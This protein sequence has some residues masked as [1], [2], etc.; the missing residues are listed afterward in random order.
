MSDASPENMALEPS[1]V[2]VPAEMPDKASQELAMLGLS[3]EFPEK[4]Q[5]LNQSLADSIGNSHS[6]FAGYKFTLSPDAVR[7][8]IETQQLY[9]YPFSVEL[10]VS[11]NMRAVLN[12][13]P[14]TEASVL[15]AVRLDQLQALLGTANVGFTATVYEPLS[16]NVSFTKPLEELTEGELTKVSP[17]SDIVIGA[18]STPVGEWPMKFVMRASKMNERGREGII[19]TIRIKDLTV[20][21]SSQVVEASLSTVSALAETYYARD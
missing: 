5:S 6:N 11:P 18:E 10:E 9:V 12:I 17:S 3:T 8:I 14:K 19:P 4:M 16:D 7:P 1:P 15:A 2:A 13:Q 20:E 21:G